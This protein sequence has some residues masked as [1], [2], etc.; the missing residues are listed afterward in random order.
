M[1]IAG[2]SVFACYWSPNTAVTMFIDFLDSLEAIIRAKNGEVI[3]AGDFN[4]K[5]PEWGIT[6]RTKTAVCYPTG[7]PA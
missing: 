1:Q 3:I 2:I 5:S 6:E 7:Q 4:A